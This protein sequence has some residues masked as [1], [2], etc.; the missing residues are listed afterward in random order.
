MDGAASGAHS[1]KS[2]NYMKYA[3]VTYGTSKFRAVRFTSYRS[4]DICGE[5]PFNGIQ[6]N[7]GYSS[8]EIY[9][10]R[11]EPL[12]WKILDYKTSLVMCLNI[13]DAQPYSEKFH[14]HTVSGA[15]SAANTAYADFYG[16]SAIYKWLNEDFYNFAFNAEE[17]E[18][19]ALTVNPELLLLHSG[20]KN[21]IRYFCFQEMKCSIQITDFR[22]HSALMTSGE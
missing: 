21:F 12:K 6:H 11:F 8:G 3:D 10:F 15:Y 22:L 18:N 13:I 20:G 14:T 2:D 7:N 5:A 4:E 19:T 17:K 1:A 16:E 9:W